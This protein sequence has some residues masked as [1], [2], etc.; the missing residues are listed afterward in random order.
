[1][2]NVTVTTANKTVKINTA[3][4]TTAD[5]LADNGIVHIIDQVLIP[6]DFQPPHTG[7]TRNILDLAAGNADLST[8]VTA[9]KAGGVADTLSRKGP[10]TF[11]APTNEAFNKLD[12][13]LLTLLL[14]PANKGKLVEVLEYHVVLGE[15]LSSELKNEEKIMTLEKQNLTVT[16]AGSTIMIKGHNTAN[17]KKADVMAVNGVIYIIDA[18]LFPPGFVPPPLETAS[19]VI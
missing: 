19:L 7:P 16:T 4:V 2:Q 13:Q 6:P 14:L 15:M 11:F 17:V 18:V 10:F 1:M 9:L 12:K 3:T 8:L 5:L